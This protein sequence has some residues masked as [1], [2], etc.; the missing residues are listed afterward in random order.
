MLLAR[1]K[2]DVR[3]DIEAR[4]QIMNFYTLAWVVADVSFINCAID[5]VVLKLAMNECPDEVCAVRF[6][7]RFG[8]MSMTPIFLLLVACMSVIVGMGLYIY[9]SL[10]KAYRLATLVIFGFVALPFHAVW[11]HKLVDALYVSIE[12][13]RRRTSASERG[14]TGNSNERGGRPRSSWT[15]RQMRFVRR[16]R[17]ISRPTGPSSPRNF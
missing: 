17:N 5:C 13:R 15:S 7:D 14:A 8:D 6:A 12:T 1:T 4:R 9:V 10:G 3:S 2:L 11:Y 16:G